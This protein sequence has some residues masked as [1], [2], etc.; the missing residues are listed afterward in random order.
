MSGRYGTVGQSEQPTNEFVPDSVV[1]RVAF[2]RLF[3]GHVVVEQKGRAN[4]ETFAEAYT[5]PEKARG[6]R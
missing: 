3:D 2:V 6:L 4:A 1:D 5:G